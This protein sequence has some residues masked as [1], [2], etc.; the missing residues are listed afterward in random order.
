M[1]NVTYS[2]LIDGT[3][4]P[5]EVVA[6]VQ[7]IE[8]EDHAELADMMRLRL[9]IGVS[10]DGSCWTLIDEGLFERLTE[11]RIAITV[12]NRSETLLTA[13]VIRTS[14]TLSNHPGESFLDVVA[15]DPTVL[16]NLEEVVRAWPDMSDSE[17]ADGIFADPKYDFVPKVKSTGVQR[18]L[19]E[20]QTIQRGTDIR[21]LQ[22]LARRN[23]YECYVEIDP[24]NGDPEG[25]FHP[26]VLDQTP[27][28]VLSV[29][30]GE[31]TNVNSF[32]ASY[33]M[34]R[35]TA[36]KVVGLDIETQ[37]DQP[38]DATGSQLSQLG[39]AS[40]VSVDHP[41]RTLLSQT[42]LAQA[43][44]LQ[45]MAQAVVEDSAWAIRAEGD[46]NTLSYGG[47]LR[48]KRPVQVRGAGLEFSGT[49][50][51]ERVL[52]TINQD[53]YT[54]RFTLRRNALG[55]PKQERFVDAEATP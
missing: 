8:I 7:Q 46:L 13:H 44:E 19:E 25:H 48:A 15:M 47:I 35:P 29:N 55:I 20:H 21:F 11:I 1:P 14:A 3:T 28:G 43:G 42:G 22:Q 38:A 54:Q 49:Y 41:R 36:V 5:A 12:D 24:E 34:L 2:L 18:T 23:G 39:E 50:Y 33:D 53:G 40:S 32:T 27:Q 45:T 17:I 9:A 52:H 26:P 16:M 6:A 37:S 51:V 10:E 31:S 4:A 30:V